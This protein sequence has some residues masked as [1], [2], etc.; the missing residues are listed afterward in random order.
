MNCSDFYQIEN[1]CLHSIDVMY[2]P[3]K[4]IPY[5][6]IEALDE[7][8][9]KLFG[10]TCRWY[11]GVF[12]LYE[13][14]ASSRS[15][16]A[17]IGSIHHIHQTLVTYCI[18]VLSL[19][20]LEYSKSN[21]VP[22][23]GIILFWNRPNMC[24]GWYTKTNSIHSCMYKFIPSDLSFWCQHLIW[25]IVEFSFCMSKLYV[26]VISGRFITRLVIP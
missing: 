3:L 1:N 25:S 26:N 10:E 24:T 9:L 17:V 13:V 6:S 12:S 14:S 5:S 22:I 11:L 20:F 16:V 8:S 7:T 2:S 21:I 23:W 19:E 18:R 4:N 15:V